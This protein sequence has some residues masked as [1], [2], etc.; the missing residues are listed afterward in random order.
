MHD[1]LNNLAVNLQP[2]MYSCRSC[3]TLELFKKNIMQACITH[4]TYIVYMKMV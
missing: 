3:L 2:S 4:L 1:A